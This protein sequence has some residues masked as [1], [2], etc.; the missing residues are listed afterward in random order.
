MRDR[1]DR[2]ALP[3]TNGRAWRRVLRIA[4]SLAAAGCATL[5][6][7]DEASGAF[8]RFNYTG[9][10]F[11]DV[12]GGM[13]QGTVYTGLLQVTLDWHV[14]P[15]TAHGDAYMPHGDSLSQRDVSVF[16]VVSNIDAVHQLRLH[17]LWG[18][19]R[20]G[21]ASV[22]LGLLAADTE[23]WGSD[24]AAL[25][26]SSAFGAPSVVSGNLQHAAIFP[27]GVLG[28]RV[29]FDIGKNDTLRIALID[30]DGGD[31]TRENRHG[32]RV[33]PNHGA[34]VVVEDQHV[35]GQ[36]AAP[37]ANALLGAHFRSRD[38]A[39]ISDAAE[40]GDWGVVGVIDRTINK[41]V[42]WFSRIGVAEPDRS[43]VPLSVE[44][45]F[46]LGAVLGARDTLGI[47]AAYIDLNGHLQSPGNPQRLR[48]EAII[49]ATLTVPLD[50]TVTVQHDL[51][52]IIAPGGTADARNA[53]VAGQRV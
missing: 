29:A 21:S 2:V 36:V 50:D 44:T 8:Y 23:F 14:G 48:H 49:E 28:A 32:L 39:D 51:Q 19:R 20:I 22:R 27:Q 38:S 53:L 12:H 31:P 9:E 33:D 25:F 11:A 10:V 7:A 24:T 13:R 37:I 43:A 1:C 26:V 18:Q 46:N 42:A 3:E 16:S 6:N 30:G 17:E 34:L 4:L 47:A 15:W 41:R 35:F 52:Y 45:G 40:R 5:A